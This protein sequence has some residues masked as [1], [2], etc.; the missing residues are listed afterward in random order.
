MAAYPMTNVSRTSKATPDAGIRV[1]VA[2][3]GTLKYRRDKTGV[4]YAI[5]IVHEWITETEFQTG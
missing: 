1:E 5:R 2:D 3:D 4:D